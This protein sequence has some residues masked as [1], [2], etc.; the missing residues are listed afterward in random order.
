[1][2][3]M[4]AVFTTPVRIGSSAYRPYGLGK[5]LLIFEYM[6]VATVCPIKVRM[7]IIT[8]ATITRISAYS[9]NP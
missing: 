1:M 7:S 6:L 2:P 4:C 5:P 3:E 9:T 8:I